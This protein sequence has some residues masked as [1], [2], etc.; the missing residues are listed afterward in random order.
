[1]SCRARVALFFAVGLATIFSAGTNSRAAAPVAN[2]ISFERDVR[3]I[4]KAHCFQCHGEG[5]KLKGGLDVRLRRSLVRG[6]EHGPAI[7]PGQP[8]KS[9]LVELIQKGEMPK[10]ER[11]LTP[12]EVRTITQWIAGGA[13]TLRPEPESL[14]K[15]PYFT[16]EERG[17]WAFQPVKRP[18]V[19]RWQSGEPVKNSIDAFLLA[20]LRTNGLAFSPEADRATL[21]RRAS[22][23]LLGLPPTPEEVAAFVADKSPSAYERMIDRLLESPDYGERWARHW[24]DVAGYAD[25]DGYTEADTVRNHS[26]KFRDYVI[27]SLN[28]DKPFDRFILEQLA[29]DELV[30]QP[31]KNLSADAIEKLTATGFLRMAPDGSASAEIESKITRNAVVA[32]T[33]KIVSTSLLGLTMGCAECHDHRYDPIPQ[34]DYYRFRAIFEPALDWKNWRAPAARLVS[35]YTDADR[36]KAKTVEADAAKLDAQRKQKEEGYINATFEKEVAK[37]PEAMREAARDARMTVAEKRT[38]AQKQL[39]KENP[40]LNVSPGSLYLYDSKAAADL[41]KMTEETAKVRAGKPVEDF[42]HV[43][44]EPA[45]VAPPVTQLFYR[46]DPDQP[47]QSLEPAEPLIFAAT[48]PAKIPAKDSSMSTSGRRLAFARSLTDG[49]HPLTARVLVNRAWLH[50]FGRG[51]VGTPG[52]F[53]FL[54]ERPTHPELLDWLASEF[55]AQGW[56]LKKLHKLI[57]TSRAWRQSSARSAEAERIDP[58]NRLLSRM[59]V[60]RIESETIRDA[61]LAVSGKLNPKQFGPAVPVM[62]DDVGQI[63]IGKE[64]KDGEGKPGAA[65]DLNGEEFRRSIYVLVR[66]SRPLG[67][68]DAF[69]APIM[70]PNCDARSATTVAPQSLML[71]N[72]KQVIEMSE[73]FARRVEREAGAEPRAQARRAWELAFSK[74][75]TSAQIEASVKHLAAQTGFY[76]AENAKAPAPTP[77]PAASANAKDKP[78]E[79][80]AKPA[81]EFSA[82]ASLCHA[83]V[84]ANGFLYVD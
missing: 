50:H 38:A 9:A 19:P 75:P 56:S 22:F 17:F 62:E 11:K 72:N 20:K 13:K 60:R 10:A 39:L 7:T 2:A 44:T 27:R 21:I 3:P 6:G 41:K 1:M 23:D 58:D 70:E 43:L 84:S 69:D 42:L 47:K 73:H 76:R 46:G 68:L 80:P 57:L 82:L 28:A 52:D 55:V 14:G 71:M 32:D 66:R 35:L 33:I 36:E 51:L 12:A 54:G 65:I 48:H 5:E 59:N 67:M 53:G 29:G 61:M 79:A 16:E 25:S 24:L 81:A 40:S 15:E 34:A 31:H 45:G 26:Y 18:A 78:K 83:L 64:N 77:A 30:P 4:L 74:R 49:Q 37:L 63:I 8:E